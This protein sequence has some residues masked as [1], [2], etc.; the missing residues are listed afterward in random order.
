MR[1][2]KKTSEKVEDFVKNHYGKNLNYQW[3]ET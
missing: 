1:K 2:L 3:K